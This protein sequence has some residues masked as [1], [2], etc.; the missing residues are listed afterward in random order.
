MKYVFRLFESKERW[1]NI[2]MKNKTGSVSKLFTPIPFFSLRI[3]MTVSV[4]IY[5]KI[6]FQLL[7]NFTVMRN[8]RG[9]YT[10]HEY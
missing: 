3:K 9:K 10:S 8:R 6:N 7:I 4:V 2:F 5:Q 1:D